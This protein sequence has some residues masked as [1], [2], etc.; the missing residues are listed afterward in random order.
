MVEQLIQM[1]KELFLY[2]NGMGV[3]KWDSF[4]LYLSR[5]LSFVTLPLYAGLLALSL[6]TLGLK[7]TGLLVVTVA[8]MITA[9]D[10]LSNFFKY[11]FGRLRPCYEEDMLATMRLVK[12]YCGG[13]YSFF[14][15]H[16]ANSVALASFFAFLLGPR[17]KWLPFLVLGWAIFVSYSRIY[18]GVHYPLDVLTGIGVGLFFGWVF[19][20]LFIF[21]QLKI[22]A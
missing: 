14:S 21:A 17:M 8:L 5:T 15:A 19:A 22:K 1:D 10:Q 9:T 20:K 11:G 13:K 7:K 18:I 12:G 2:L 3:P 16:A 6:R 4:W